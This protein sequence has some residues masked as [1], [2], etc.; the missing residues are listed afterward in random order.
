MTKDVEKAILGRRQELSDE[1]HE[2]ILDNPEADA[3]LSRVAIEEA[4]CDG[5]TL[6]VARQ[7]YGIDAVDEDEKD[8]DV[9]DYNRLIGDVL[10]GKAGPSIPG[11]VAAEA[12]RKLKVE[13]EARDGIPY[14]PNEAPDLSEPP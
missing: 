6:E 1:D 3:Y 13:I 14:M 7:L 9:E 2:R 4:V 10:E 5:M 12:F 11:P 8:L